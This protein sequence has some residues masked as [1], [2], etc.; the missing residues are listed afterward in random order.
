MQTDKMSTN[1]K[2]C[3]HNIIKIYK[4][5]NFIILLIFSVMLKSNIKKWLN[6]RKCGL[7]KGFPQ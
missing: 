3:Q 1:H 4:T 2:L 6:L 7:I 5:K